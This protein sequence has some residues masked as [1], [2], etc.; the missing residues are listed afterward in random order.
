MG[1]GT[2]AVPVKRE[3]LPLLA[4]DG[5]LQGVGVNAVTQTAE[6]GVERV[7][8]VESVWA[9]SLFFLRTSI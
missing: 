3:T 5:S 1:W 2:H 4:E 8:S 9:K 6:G 7:G